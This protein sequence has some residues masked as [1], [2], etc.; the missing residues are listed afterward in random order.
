[1]TTL[2]QN[3]K[4]Q[5][6]EIP[7]SSVFQEIEKYCSYGQNQINQRFISS[8]LTNVNFQW[9]LDSAVF[10]EFSK[11]TRF[12]PFWPFYGYIPGKI[13]KNGQKLKIG[14]FWPFL[15]KFWINLAIF[16]SIYK[17]DRLDNPNL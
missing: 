7:K 1:L 2:R 9:T 5:E 15:A 12:W 8:F 14:H 11:K 17:I 16:G 10:E 3:T 6:S 13:R 4:N